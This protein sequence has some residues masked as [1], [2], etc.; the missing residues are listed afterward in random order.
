M[1]TLNSLCQLN[2]EFFILYF[3]WIAMDNS[4][5]D[6]IAN[7]QVL[8][9][10]KLIDQGKISEAN[11]CTENSKELWDFNLHSIGFSKRGMTIYEEL[12]S[13]IVK[14]AKTKGIEL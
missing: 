12:K 7:N 13:C 9:I 8:Y 10:L 11:A 14:I 3:Y 5:I 4:K 1:T 2:N 6:E